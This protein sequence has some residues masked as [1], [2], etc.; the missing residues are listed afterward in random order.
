MDMSLSCSAPLALVARRER[1]RGSIV[2]VF[3]PSEERIPGGAVGMLEAGVMDDPK[4]DAVFG[5]HLTQSAPVGSVRVRPGPSMASAD[6]FQAEILGRGGHAS[7]PH[8][9]IDPIRI[10]ASVVTALHSIVSREVAPLDAAVITIGTLH[11][12]SV[13]NVIPPSA[14]FGGS[15]RAFDQRVRETLARRIEVPHMPR[16][17]ARGAARG[18][19]GQTNR[20]AN[21]G[22]ESPA[23]PPAPDRRHRQALA[24]DGLFCTSSAEERARGQMN[25]VHEGVDVRALPAAEHQ[26]HSRCAGGSCHRPAT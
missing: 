11:A 7:R 5:L 6:T 3:Q 20:M 21:R 19:Y 16:G 10:A 22:S 4:V 1:L 9:A 26:R 2:F 8:Q 24:H 12:G 17:A 18:M 15:V 25:A 14:T 23:D 13:P